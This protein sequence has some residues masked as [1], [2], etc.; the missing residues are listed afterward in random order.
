MDRSV[1]GVIREA[2]FSANRMYISFT[3]AATDNGDLSPR[4][5]PD[6]CDQSKLESRHHVSKYTQ[7]GTHLLWGM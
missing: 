3:V 7:H 2:S 1:K 6:G 5:A 4:G